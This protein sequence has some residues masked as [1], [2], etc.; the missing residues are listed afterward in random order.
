M[1]KQIPIY[2]RRSHSHQRKNAI[3][4]CIKQPSSED[5]DERTN[6]RDRQVWE[7]VRFW[8]CAF[9]CVCVCKRNRRIEKPTATTIIGVHVCVANFSTQILIQTP[10]TLSRIPRNQESERENRTS[11]Q[12]HFGSKWKSFGFVLQ[13]LQTLRNIEKMGK[14]SEIIH[15]NHSVELALFF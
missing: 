13:L 12:L 6:E 15:W 7:C 4:S 14:S 10:N 5:D 2:K 11:I 8:V 1:I 9:R 3:F